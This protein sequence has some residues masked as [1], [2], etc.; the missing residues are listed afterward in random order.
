MHRSKAPA[1]GPIKYPRM[2]TPEVLGVF[3]GFSFL[4]LYF[5][6]VAI[7]WPESYFRLGSTLE[8]VIASGPLRYVAFRFIPVFV[9]CLFVAVSVER[10]GGRPGITV[11]LVVALHLVSTTGWAA[12]LVLSGRRFRSRR[13]PL[14]AAYAAISFGVVTA[15]ALPLAFHRELAPVVPDPAELNA[16]LWTAGLAGV[17]GAY[18]TQLG[19]RRG[20][21][22]ARSIQRSKAS[23]DPGLWQVAIT[24]ARRHGVNPNVVFAFMVVENLQRPAW[25]RSL[26]NRFGRWWGRG[27]YGILQ[28]PSDA[29]ISDQESIAQFIRQRLAPVPELQETWVPEGEY[30][31]EPE[32][33]DVRRV[34]VSHNHDGEYADSV[35]EALKLIW[36]DPPVDV[37]SR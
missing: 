11:A 20:E 2:T 19:L 7:R 24:E 36:E 26:E 17:A 22:V 5:R 4:W 30:Y 13:V 35:V 9:T 12:A 1:R 34:A 16:T 18:I 37:P 29:P 3:G 32:L 25:F 21:R 23:I 8:N 10:A 28:V 31:T 15:A 33:D 14:M 27:T 6:A